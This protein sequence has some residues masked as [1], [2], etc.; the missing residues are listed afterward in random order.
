MKKIVISL[1][2]W[3]SMWANAQ[4]NTLLNGNFWKEKP[5]LETVKQEINKGNN[6]ADANA[7]NH[8]VVSIAINND[9]PFE[10]ITYLIAQPGNSISKQTHDGRLYIHWAANKGNIALIRFLLE[11]GSDIHATDD[12]GATPLSYAAGNGQLNT[13]VYELLFNAGVNPTTTYKDGANLLH[14]IAPYDKDGKISDFLI[15]KGLSL[16][17]TDQK[18]RTVFD[19]ACRTG[20]IEI[21]KKLLEKG[22]KP[23]DQALFF[24][25][26]GTRFTAVK[27]EVYHYLIE[28]VGLN[29]KAVNE[30]G[31]NILHVLVKKKDQ[32]QS[33]EYFLNK[34]ID[35]N[36]QDKNGNTV[37]SNATHSKDYNLVKSL[38]PLVNN[39]NVANKKGETALYAAIQH[40]TIDIAEM[41]INLGADTQIVSKDGN[42]AFALIQSYKKPRAGEN[43]KDFED[44]LEMLQRINVSFS[45]THKGA[46]LYHIAI[47]KDDLNLLKLLEGKNIEL[48]TLD[49][50]GMTVLH[51]AA[52]M[53][54]DINILKYLISIG[55]N[56]SMKTEMDETA[57]ELAME[58]ELLKTQKVDL[59]F[60]K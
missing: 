37:F 1:A 2:L 21:L 38:T 46:S 13:E 15:N 9:A 17:S 10:V 55:A 57:Y 16:K 47:V 22:V 23:T 41:L 24:A 58:N 54:K 49:N 43:N 39:I 51:K 36:A 3:V 56:K 34:N 7:G 33:I 6:P 14:L 44:K 11:K 18:N 20:N 19:Y 29:P 5:N 42:L 45:N 26:Q 50:N 31:E 25:A 8:D 48:N 35:I 4:Q 28:K 30:Q 12:K 52:S 32:Q 59:S 53:T 40:G 60:L 27:P